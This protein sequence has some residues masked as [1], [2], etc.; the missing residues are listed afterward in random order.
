M[1]LDKD[2]RRN[3]TNAQVSRRSLFPPINQETQ[4]LTSHTPLTQATPTIPPPLGKTNSNPNDNHNDREH[5]QNEE[6]H[7]TS[8]KE[9]AF[10][11]AHAEIYS[12]RL[13]E[14]MI[15]FQFCGWINYWWDQYRIQEQEKKI[16][17]LAWH[18]DDKESEASYWKGSFLR[19]VVV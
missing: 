18:M 16:R 2:C 13:V 19:G 17:D 7:S 6:S 15:F 8:N 4:H 12:R 14:T 3:Q 10:Q 11:R 9:K 5:T 1:Y